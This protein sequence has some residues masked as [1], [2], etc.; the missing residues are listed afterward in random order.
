M[1]ALLL[2]AAYRIMELFIHGIK[3]MCLQK[4][5]EGKELESS[6]DI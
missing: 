4:D 6:V 3:I 2:Q 5:T 1:N